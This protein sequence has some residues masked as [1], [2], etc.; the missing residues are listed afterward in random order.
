MI[1]NF[2]TDTNTYEERIEGTYLGIRA[3]VYVSDAF[4]IGF[5]GTLPSGSFWVNP[6]RGECKQVFPSKYH[7]RAELT[8]HYEQWMAERAVDL[9]KAA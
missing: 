6:F 8:Y 7:A 3:A 4:C 9:L 5:Y 1:S 2:S